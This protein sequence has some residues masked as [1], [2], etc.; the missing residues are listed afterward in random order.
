MLTL[1]KTDPNGLIPTLRRWRRNMS[2][3]K[4]GAL[5]NPLF[6]LH[7]GGA[8][9]PVF[10]DIDREMP[11]LR[12]IDAAYDTIRGEFDQVLAA[13]ERLPSYHS[14]DTDV[15]HSSGRLQRDRRW[16]VFML[17]CFGRVPQAARTLAPRTLELV[18]DIPG[19]YQAMFSILEPG[20]SVRAHEGPS[21]MY[22]RYHL[23]LRVP[24]VRPP[25]IRVKDR[26][27]QWKERESVLFDDSWDHEVVNDSPELRAILMID[28][29]RPMPAP[30]RMV[31][32]GMAT[33]ASLHYAPRIVRTMDALVP[34]P[35]GR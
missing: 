30:L 3:Y 13:Y 21:R 26:I 4:S 15:I 9:R 11:A 18:R 5:F 23:A 32:K 7:T 10:H 24:A 14:I 29:A 31:A 22:L 33:M 20:K 17:T 2:L 28:V 12:R 1:Q 16:S 6:D 8:S 25:H 34:P 19:V 27:H 35:P